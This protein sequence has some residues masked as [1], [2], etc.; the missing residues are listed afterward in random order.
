MA[1]QLAQRLAGSEG[2]PLAVGKE[3]LW[4]RLAE[5]GKLARRTK[6]RIKNPDGKTFREVERHA[7][8]KKI[9]GYMRNLLALW[10]NDLRG[11]E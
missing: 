3:T 5:A 1:Y 2:I 7:H 4:S 10:A 6:E 11:T 8:K 9:G